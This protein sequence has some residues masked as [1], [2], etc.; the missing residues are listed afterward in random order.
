MP[1][2]LPSVTSTVLSPVAG[3]FEAPA[4]ITSRPAACGPTV[5]SP[6]PSVAVAEVVNG[7]GERKVINSFLIT[8]NGGRRGRYAQTR[9][10]RIAAEHRMRP[11]NPGIDHR[12]VNALAFVAVG[13]T[14]KRSQVVRIAA[15]EPR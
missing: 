13:K 2:R 7:A 3:S 4:A 6:W 9:R 10:S 8:V 5:A 15:V 14:G 1:V 12:N 11:I